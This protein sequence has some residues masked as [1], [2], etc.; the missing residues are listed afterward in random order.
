M[1]YMGY[2]VL[3][4]KSC[5]CHSA[6]WS[7]ASQI[8]TVQ[9]GYYHQDHTL[10]LWECF[11]GHPFRDQPVR[12]DENMHQLW[13]SVERFLLSQFPKTTK[14]TI[15]FDDPA[16]DT[17]E[18]QEFLRSCGYSPVAKAAYGKT[19]SMPFSM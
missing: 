18:Y 12:E 1:G 17:K 16:F 15:P 9:A 5:L 19:I 4:A 7:P 6:K 14:L 2:H 13:T 10:A 8:G 3:P 11:L